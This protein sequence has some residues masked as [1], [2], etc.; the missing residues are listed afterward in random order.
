MRKKIHKVARE[1]APA[2]QEDHVAFIR[3][4][5]MTTMQLT[6]NADT[7]IH[8]VSARTKT[9]ENH[10]HQPYFS[11]LSSKL[12]TAPWINEEPTRIVDETL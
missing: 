4:S 3:P 12:F 5:P 9:Q 1:K 8:I 10:M 11:Q 2:H 7:Y 6:F